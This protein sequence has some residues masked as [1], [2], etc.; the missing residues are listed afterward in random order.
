MK[1]KFKKIWNDWERYSGYSQ[2]APGQRV[3]R[4]SVQEAEADAISKYCLNDSDKKLQIIEIGPGN[5][6]LAETLFNK[7]DISRYVLV[8]GPPQLELAE[9]R[10][11]KYSNHIE[12]YTPDQIYDIQ[13]EFDLFISCH[14]LPETPHTYQEQIHETFFSRCNMLMIAQTLSAKIGPAGPNVESLT[15]CLEQ[16]FTEYREWHPGTEF[17]ELCTRDHQRLYIA[18]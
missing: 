15:K 18:K 7:Y 14:C 17:P 16:Y 13:G 9:T 2:S 11:S 12:T 10:L 1:S 4:R 3:S 8:D 6:I 5:G